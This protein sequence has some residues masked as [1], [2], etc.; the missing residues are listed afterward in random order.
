MPDESSCHA[1]AGSARNDGDEPER[2]SGARAAQTASP[3]ITAIE[4]ENFKGIGRPIR[5]DLRPIILLFGNNSAGKSTIL[6]ALC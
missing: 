3:L 5:I 2:G 4:I 1:G 6:H